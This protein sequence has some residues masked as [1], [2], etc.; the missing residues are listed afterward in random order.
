MRTN[1]F[2]KEQ[3]YEMG[4]CYYHAVNQITTEV[5]HGSKSIKSLLTDQ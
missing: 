1:L 3:E 5:E 4:M 2:C